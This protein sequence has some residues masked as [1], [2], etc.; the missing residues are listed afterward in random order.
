MTNKQRKMYAILLKRKNNLLKTIA[1]DYA[2]IRTV[3][4]NK[5]V[6]STIITNVMDQLNQRIHKHNNDVRE[7][8][9]NKERSLDL[10]VNIIFLGF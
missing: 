6:D 8:K 5:S 9:F 4:K 10:L 1:R 7:C 2:D 3:Q